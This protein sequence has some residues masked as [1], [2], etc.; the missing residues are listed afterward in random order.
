MARTAKFTLHPEFQI[1]TVDSRLFGSFLEHLGRAIYGGI[2]EPDH[3]S[4]DEEGFR[5]DVMK[6]VRAMETPL[7]RYPGGNFVSGYNWEDGIGPK[8][9]RPRRLDLAWKSIET[10]QVGINEFVTWCRK[11][12]AEAMI[13]VNLGTRGAEAARNLVEYCNHPGGTYWSDLRRS[14]G[15]KDPHNIRTWCLGNEMDGNW[16]IGH[17]TAEEYGHLACETAKV[18]KWVDPT[19][20]LVA[21]GSSFP[22][23]PTFP[24]WEE[25]VLDHTYDLVD[26]ISLHIYLGNPENDTAHYL[27]KPLEMDRY[28]STV[29]N[30]CDVVK[31]KTHSKKA[32][33]LSFDEWNVYHE[34]EQ[35]EAMKARP[36]LVAPPLLENL[37]TMEDALVFGEMLITLLKHSERV[38][39][40]CL[41][42]LVNVLAPIM[43]VKGGTCWRQPTYY[44]FINASR[45]GRGEVL[46]LNIHSPAY[47]DREYGPVPY[48]DAVTVWSRDNETLTIFA[49]NRDTQ[50]D[51]P[52]EGDVR[53]FTG[54]H[55]VEYTTL[56]HRDLKTCNTPEY[57][58]RIVPQKNG[59]AHLDEGTLRASLPKASWNVIRLVADRISTTYAL[60]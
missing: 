60:Q 14:H 8:S 42:Q 25:T 41:A 15:F 46:N 38:R 18:M 11:V 33:Y 34:W 22:G 32:L 57:P 4:A 16:Q 1:G 43:T 7:V 6:I 50:A 51:L 59:N 52:I 30:I 20:E 3:H 44:P 27:A 31:A 12:G 5:Q 19:I 49:V 53:A 13:T 45:F 23:M 10:N 36:W 29:A 47:E 17:K 28:I 37:Y 40:A 26:Y 2:Y 55:L 21:C 39:I 54:Y 24:D 9:Q 35:P 58:N 48:L 56:S